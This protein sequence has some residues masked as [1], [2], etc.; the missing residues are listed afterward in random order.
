MKKIIKFK[1]ITINPEEYYDGILTRV[2][3]DEEYGRIRLFVELDDFEEE[4]MKSLKYSENLRS[5]MG[6]FFKELGVLNKKGEL[7]LKSLE[8][9]GVEVTLKQGKDSQWYIN[10]MRLAV[11]QESS[12]DV[13]DTGEEEDDAD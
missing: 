2:E 3:V 11:Y 13:F 12:D 7:N 6:A 1:T 10:K 8:G 4:F 9:R 5:P